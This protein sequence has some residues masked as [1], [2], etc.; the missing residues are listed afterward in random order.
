MLGKLR[1]PVP[2]G[3]LV[4]SV[5]NKEILKQ[6]EELRGKMPNG[7]ITL[8]K[9]SVEDL[10]VDHKELRDS[11]RDL[12]KSLLDPD[13]GVVV[14]VNKN[15]EFRREREDSSEKL[16][17]LFE[18][19]SNLIQWKDSISKILWILFT[20]IIGLVIKVLWNVG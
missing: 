1:K 3:D 5:T 4:V 7:S 11:I 10:Q 20:A 14:R 18:Q 12:K 2:I 6:I 17:T 9:K 8:L 13:N 16:S 19:V 15:S